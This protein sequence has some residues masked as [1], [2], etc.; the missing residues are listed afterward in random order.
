MNMLSLACKSLWSRRT[1]VTLIVVS[2]ALSVILILGV[3]RIRAETREHFTRTVS[4]TDLIVGARSSPTQV[5]LYTVFRMGDPTGNITWKSYQQI[6]AHPKVRFAIPVSLGDS[7]RG[8]RVLGTT[9]AYFEH[10]AYGE[11]RSLV[12]AEGRGFESVFDAV[13]GAEVAARLGYRVGD[14]VIL[15]H[16]TR[17]D[18]L[19]RHNDRPFSVTGVLAPTGTPVD[20]TVHVSLA[21]IDVIHAGW[22]TGAHR[23]DGAASQSGE[24]QPADIEPKSITAFFIG[25]HS[26]MD[27]FLLQRAINGFPGEALTAILPGVALQALWDLFG[28]AETALVVV[29]S[30]TLL[31][32][33]LGMIA[34]ILATLNERRREI[35]VYRAVGARMRDIVALLVA[36]STLLAL[37]GAVLGTG[38]LT[39]ATAT[40]GDFAR[41]HF[42][43]APSTGMPSPREWSL[44]AVIVLTGSLA[45][46]I[47]AWRAYRLSL[48]DGLTAGT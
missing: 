2:I 18:G 23:V 39:L 47:P 40:L 33:V 21:G 10:L 25:L 7:H 35:A 6:S 9:G 45:G 46:L 38:M 13:L 43:F 24:T 12:F 30:L 15:A 44:L 36:E 8:Y 26:R 20:S 48:H 19:S 16:G 34:G 28:T 5:L 27:V 17:D 11:G 29:T 4:G 22:G 3:D 37:A 31:T 41:M 32:G 14:A 1:G 42:G